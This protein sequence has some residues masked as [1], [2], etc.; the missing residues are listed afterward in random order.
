MENASNITN[1]SRRYSSFMAEYRMVMSWTLGMETV[2]MIVGTLLNLWLMLSILTSRDLRVRMRNQLIVNMSIIN[3]VQTVIKSPVL[4]LKCTAILHKVLLT[5]EFFC[6]TY[7]IMTVVEFTQSFISD[8][9]MVF[10]IAI[11]IA[12]IM[13]MDLESK[14]TPQVSRLMKA[15]LHLL[16]WFV[17]IV[18]TTISISQVT[19]W[20]PCLLIP[21][22]NLYIFEIVYTII[23]T[24]LAVLLMVAAILLRIRRF[25][26]GSSTADGNMGVQLIGKGP[27]IDNTFAYMLA[28]AICVACE[29]CNLIFVFE[30]MDWKYRG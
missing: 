15:I 25:N 29:I 9:L 4:I 26:R 18:I 28:G 7:S 13:D 11:F 6:H 17:A 23:P 22:R 1:A 10:I 27:E 14:V 12:N 5:R 30:I 8:W 24:S 20:Y 21:Y 3:L 2:F 16:P 19:R